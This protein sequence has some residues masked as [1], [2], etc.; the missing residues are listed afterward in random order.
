MYENND[1]FRIKDIIHSL[2]KNHW[3]SKQ[4]LADTFKN[5]YKFDAGKMCVVGGWYGLTAYQLRRQFQ[6]ST[7]H[8][9]SS[10]MDPECAYIGQQIFRSHNIDFK[11]FNMFDQSY[12][13]CNA[14]ISTSAEHVDRDKLVE[15][16]KNKHRRTWVVLQSNNYFDH[17]THINCSTS[18]D[19]FKSYLEP[20]LDI[21]WVGTL[22]NQGFNRFMVIG[23]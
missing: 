19:E 15:L 6:S 13:D 3:E 4:W 23:K 11:T 20:Y 18:A 5:F 17:P 10:D 16:V 8:I 1:I 9:V 12:D 22:P 2:D 7:M 14:L 21:Y